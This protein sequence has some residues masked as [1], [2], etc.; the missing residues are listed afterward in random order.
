VVTPGGTATVDGGQ[1]TILDTGW[2]HWLP[3]SGERFL[4]LARFCPPRQ[5]I[6]AYGTNSVI[7]VSSDGTLMLTS[8]QACVMGGV[9]TIAAVRQRLVK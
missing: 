1:V 5:V 6:L 2:P 8:E 3:K 9:N 4:L 7:P